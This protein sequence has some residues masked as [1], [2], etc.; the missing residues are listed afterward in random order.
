MTGFPTG[1]IPYPSTNC[2]LNFGTCYRAV[3]GDKAMKRDLLL[4]GSVWLAGLMIGAPTWGHPRL[5]GEPPCIDPSVHEEDGS[6]NHRVHC[7][8]ADGTEWHFYG[9][10]DVSMT[11]QVILSNERMTAGNGTDDNHS[12]SCRRASNRGV[13][14]IRYH[15]KIGSNALC[16]V[17]WFVSRG[18]LMDDEGNQIGVVMSSSSHCSSRVDPASGFVTLAD[19]CKTWGD[20]SKMKWCS[21]FDSEDSSSSEGFRVTDR[22]GCRRSSPF[23]PKLSCSSDDGEGGPS[24]P[25]SPA[26]PTP[27]GGPAPPGDPTPEAETDEFVAPYWFASGGFTVRAADGRSVRVTCGRTTREYAAESNGIVTRLV[28][29]RCRGGLKVKGAEPGGWYWQ[30]NERNAA[31]AMLVSPSALADDL[32]EPVV[33]PGGVE[34]SA[35]A[36]GT[37]IFHETSR[38]VGIVPHL[39]DNVCAEYIAPCW[40]GHGGL[41]VQPAPGRESV[42]V[43]V[44][45][46]RTYSTQRLVAGEDGIAA[47]LIEKPYCHD[48]N[49]NPKLGKLTVTGAEPGGWYWIDGDRNAAVSPLVCADLL[50][51]PDAVDP[52]G[53]VVERSLNCTHFDHDANG[54]IGIVPHLAGDEQH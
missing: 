38:L 1:P 31:V 40:R 8:T 53:V 20:D 45:C 19:S 3:I 52:G 21:E 22:Q 17:H 6:G 47:D 12:G 51:G 16:E 36:T 49:G 34:T 23:N 18:P 5:E 10:D 41:V 30:N 48:N 9:V 46:G 37:R 27:P 14:S 24:P 42:A 28:T 29:S 33:I 2:H 32:D 43:T 54:L 15:C 44:Q 26:N 39:A 7:A 4:I 13:G 11:S 25:S 35:S 50:G